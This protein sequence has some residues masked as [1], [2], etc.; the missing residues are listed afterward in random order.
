MH[1][2]REAQT[3]F[4]L[5]I[6]RYPRSQLLEKAKFFQ[7]KTFILTGRKIQAE[8]I[9]KELIKTKDTKLRQ[10]VYVTL[11][12]LYYSLGKYKQALDTYMFIIK[13]LKVN[14]PEYFEVIKKQGITLTHLEKKK[15]ID[16]GRKL[17]YYYL[18]IVESHP[19]KDEALFGLAESYYRENNHVAAQKLYNKI[20]EQ[21]H[22]KRRPVVLSRFRQAQYLDDPRQ[23]LENGK[24]KVTWKIQP[25]M[26]HILKC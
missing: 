17:L 11:G 7:A 4:K 14:S 6:K 25:E 15:S 2:L 23:Q 16:K 9:Y 18:N 21:D 8:K 24:K 10:N 1:S 3:Y 5:F 26:H 12:D 22:S 19:L 13:E 20:L